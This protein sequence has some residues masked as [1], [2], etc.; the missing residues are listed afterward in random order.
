MTGRILPDRTEKTTLFL[1]RERNGFPDGRGGFRSRDSHPDLLESRDERHEKRDWR[2]REGQAP[3]CPAGG[4]ALECGGK[5]SATPLWI[6]IGTA[7]THAKARRREGGSRNYECAK[8]AKGIG[9]GVRCHVRAVQREQPEQP[10]YRPATRAGVVSR[11]ARIRS[12]QPTAN[13][14]NHTNGGGT[15]VDAPVGAGAEWGSAPPGGSE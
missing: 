9:F 13:Y 15:V 8:S 10:S 12:E 6:G 3:S 1:R 2:F 5:R 14:T 7:V 4:S 11:M